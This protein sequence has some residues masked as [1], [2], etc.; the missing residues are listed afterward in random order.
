M[1]LDAPT[2]GML[3]TIGG[4]SIIVTVVVEI[5]LRAWSPSAATKDRFGP[6]LALAVGVAFAV[7]GSIANGTPDP[8]TGVL[9]GVICAGTGMGIH[10][11]ID[12]QL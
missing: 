6:L 3:S 8:L 2:A 7:I 5:I 4:L 1:T 11:T 10:D 12:S 9:L